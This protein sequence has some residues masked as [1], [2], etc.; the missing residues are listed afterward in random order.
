[1]AHLV[2]AEAL[3]GSLGSLTVPV[4]SDCHPLRSSVENYFSASDLVLGNEVCG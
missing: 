3:L 4:A 2:G 1:M